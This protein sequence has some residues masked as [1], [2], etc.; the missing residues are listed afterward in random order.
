MSI[1]LEIVEEADGIVW[2]SG[3]IPEVGLYDA[4]HHLEQS[5]FRLEKA[6]LRLLEE[7]V[8]RRYW[9]MV[10]RDLLRENLGESFFRGPERAWINW[11][12]LRKYARKHGFDLEQ[13]REKAAVLL[14]NYLTV[15]YEAVESGRD[16]HTMGLN[17][18]DLLEFARELGLDPE[19]EPN[20]IRLDSFKSLGYRAAIAAHRRRASQGENT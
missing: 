4:L 13:Y 10:Q 7:A 11:Q 18:A 16:Y 12:R 6:E 14:K 3:E 8:T 19:L 20:I 17:S 2:Q 5:G 15:E 1:R 9:D